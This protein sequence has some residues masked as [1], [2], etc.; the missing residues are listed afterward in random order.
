MRALSKDEKVIMNAYRLWYSGTALNTDS[1]VSLVTYDDGAVLRFIS[2]LNDLAWEIDT[3]IARIDISEHSVI[4]LC[5]KNKSKIYMDI[6]VSTRNSAE[7][8]W[9]RTYFPVNEKCY[10]E[11]YYTYVFDC[12]ESNDNKIG[13]V[14][15]TSESN[16]TI[17]FHY[18][19]SWEDSIVYLGF[20]TTAED[21]EKFH[22]DYLEN[23]DEFRSHPFIYEKIP[24][25]L[26]S[27]YLEKAEKM[28][29]SV[30]E[31]ADIELFSI[32]GAC[33]YV[34]SIH[35][36]D[37]NDGRSPETPFKSPNK[38]WKKT[39]DGD[40]SVINSGD[41]VFFERGSVFYAAERT[42]YTGDYALKIFSGITYSAYGK[43]EK[44]VFTNAVRCDNAGIWHKSEY[45][46]VW[47]F[48]EKIK[49]W[50]STL[51]YCDI[52]NIIFNH[53]D[54][55]GIKVL[56]GNPKDP[57]NKDNITVDCGDVYNGIE[58]YYSGRTE[59][60]NPGYLKNN[61]E[62]FHNWHTGDL[63]LYFDK[64]NPGEHFND[65][66]I[67]KNGH[68]IRSGE[69]CA[70]VIIDNLCVKYTGS[71]GFQCWNSK[72]ITVQNCEFGWIGGGVQGE[73]TVRY[74]N[75]VENWGACDG[76]SV[77]NCYIYQ[78]YDTGI[79]TQGKF[80]SMKNGNFSKNIIEYCN[81]GFEVWNAGDSDSSIENII[82]SENIQLFAGYGFGLQRPADNKNG[83]FSMGLKS[84]YTPC[85][86]VV[87]ENNINLYT[88]HFCN[89]DGSV[90]N[91]YSHWEGITFRKNIYLMSSTKGGILRSKHNISDRSGDSK[92]IYPYT[93]RYIRYITDLGIEKD[94]VFYY[95][96]EYLPYHNA[97]LCRKFM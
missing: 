24:A 84:Y 91:K 72:N 6:C 11:E 96:D 19:D 14:R 43:G 85:R 70:D 76:L 83:A 12:A 13:I 26:L 89:G 46:N 39:P 5:T 27:E 3:K 41:G 79:T 61:L 53:G 17:R 20:F 78:C 45:E 9:Q 87:Y 94:S 33:W 97:K 48:D 50:N 32:S 30:R 47:V 7:E 63:Y 92:T 16:I 75:A 31:A 74:G 62:Y 65:V 57:Y 81:T 37:E 64:G 36:N 68:V 22:T 35:G 59:F 73:G 66:K 18:V 54:A 90:T 55:W 82:V 4:K 58:R 88:S 93:P 21:A 95:Y 25:K 42:N 71:H 1:E 44:P 40:I 2:I 86:N 69:E 28:K 34:S 38:L 52:G 67:S 80:C 15:G 77:R 8:N 56:P 10:C 49:P 29:A 60:K 23:T 51:N